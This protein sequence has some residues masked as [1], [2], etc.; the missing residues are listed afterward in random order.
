M[1]S[2][3]QARY[4]NFLFERGIEQSNW[5]GRKIRRIKRGHVTQTQRVRYPHLSYVMRFM[6]SWTTFLKELEMTDLREEETG[7]WRLKGL[8]AGSKVVDT[9]SESHTPCQQESKVL[10]N[11][12]Q[13]SCNCVKVSFGNY[14]GYWLIE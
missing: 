4:S 3:M 10:K 2:Y 6:C 14:V 13:L 11:M 8:E 7:E 12:L 5:K 9:I 1:I